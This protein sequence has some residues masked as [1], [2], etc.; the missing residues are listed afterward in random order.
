AVLRAGRGDPDAA[1]GRDRDVRLAHHAS[2]PKMCINCLGTKPAMRTT[3]ST[4]TDQN[5]VFWYFAP[6]DQKS[7]RM[8]RRPLSAWSPIAPTSAI[9]PR[10]MIG[11]LYA[12]MTAL[13]AS[14]LTLTSAVS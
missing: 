3:Q 2:P 5:I 6:V 14:G 13:Y 10:P 8:I 12:P 9:S 11:V 4:M 1:D 7:M